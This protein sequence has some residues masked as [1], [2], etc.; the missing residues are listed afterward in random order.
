MT[1][2]KILSNIFKN[3][4]LKE[5]IDLNK[6]RALDHLSFIN[7]QMIFNDTPITARQSS[8]QE[9][10]Y[11]EYEGL[12]KTFDLGSHDHLLYFINE[13]LNE[14]NR[15][16]HHPIIKI[17]HLEVDVI[18]YTKDYNSITESDVKLSKAIDEIFNDITYIDEL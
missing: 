5:N 13:V 2:S 16:D 9:F 6:N 15:I 1:T 17:D 12:N 11:G 4:S 18:L 10:D 7:R 8:W 3:S 14:S